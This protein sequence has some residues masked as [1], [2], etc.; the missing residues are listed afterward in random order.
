MPKNKLKAQLEL[1]ADLEAIR[2]EYDTYAQKIQTINAE[3]ERIVFEQK[4]LKKAED[5]F[6]EE[7]RILTGEIDALRNEKTMLEAEIEVKNT[8]S[9]EMGQKLEQL[10][11]KLTEMRANHDMHKQM[12]QKE[13]EEAAVR[14][15]KRKEQAENIQS[16]LTTLLYEHVQQKERNER[17]QEANE[18]LQEGYERL[19]RDCKGVLDNLDTQREAIRVEKEELD[20]RITTLELLKEEVNG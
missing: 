16:L 4:E 9:R 12:Y 10:E 2:A 5:R 14:V 19:K 1:E 11:A 8:S 3:D 7:K 15:K 17:L 20:R 6:I 18:S 13:E